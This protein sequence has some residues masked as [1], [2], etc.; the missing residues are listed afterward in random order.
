MQRLIT[1]RVSARILFY[2]KIHYYLYKTTNCVN[3]QSRLI[4]I[5]VFQPMLAN[6]NYNYQMLVYFLV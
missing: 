3:V 2:L 6:F 4:D 5:R 1:V